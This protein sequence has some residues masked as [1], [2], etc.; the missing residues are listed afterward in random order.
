MMYFQPDLTAA[1]VGGLIL[2][3]IAVLAFPFLRR[4]WRTPSRYPHTRRGRMVAGVLLTGA[5]MTSFVQAYAHEAFVGS[6]GLGELFGGFGM[7]VV[8]SLILHP[9]EDRR[10]AKE[11]GQ[12]W[13]LPADLV[14]IG[15]LGVWTGIAYGTM[16]FGIYKV[17]QLSKHV[18]QHD[19][20]AVNRLVAGFD[21][22]FVL[23]LIG[24][25]LS[26]AV[27][28]GAVYFQV[29]RRRDATPWAAP[30]TTS[31]KAPTSA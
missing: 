9:P 13:V 7:L 8:A 18:P 28:G 17:D 21:T 12:P 4:A 27:I 19:A 1:V 10:L 15:L 26:L 14:A 3:G 11:A 20:T 6:I 16:K 24:A 23:W 31:R 30:Q 5:V 25:L 29:R 22:F 2:L